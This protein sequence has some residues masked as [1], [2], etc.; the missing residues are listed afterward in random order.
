M[1]I[2]SIEYINGKEEIAFAEVNPFKKEIKLLKK[3]PKEAKTIVSLSALDTTFR[4]YSFPIKDKEKIKNL[5]EGQLKFDLPVPIDQIE[6]A[7]FIKENQAFCVITKKE[8]IK[9]LKEENGQIDEI[10]SDIFAIIRL[11]KLYHG[12]SG[13][14]IHMYDEHN[15]FY[16][17]FEN[18]FP[19]KVNVISDKEM[20]NFYDDE[21]YLSGQ[22]PKQYIENAQI[23]KNPFN[24][25]KL[26][27]LSG[28]LL[29]PIFTEIGIDF[30]H[31]ERSD[32]TSKFLVSVLILVLS[33]L[34]ID[35]GLTIQN[36]FLQKELNKVKAAEKE[37]FIKYFSQTTPVFDPL[38]QARG[39]VSSAKNQKKEKFD[40]ISV[41]NDIGKAKKIA[42]IK[43]IY[44][45]N[46]N[47]LEFTIKGI[48]VNL[49]DIETFKNILSSKYNV[50]IEET[51][52]NVEGEIRFSIK[53][54]YK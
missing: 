4:L 34:F 39:L 9:A 19:K 36:L 33:I 46:V 3:E 13:K 23:L 47:P 52:T 7:Y 50:R 12:N 20:Q 41:L 45:I 22:I 38:S 31:K 26:S 30:L 24:D 28:I 32:L 14:V 5:I 10:D 42:K 11:F 25:P 54:K 21:T 18:T 43:E 37:I 2:R 48:A 15:G 29:K 1:I 51:V 17:E 44:Q 35:I 49:K 6:Y 16:L 8:I 53:G 27:I 40:A